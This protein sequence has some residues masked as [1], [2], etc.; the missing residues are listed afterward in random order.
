[1]KLFIKKSFLFGFCVVAILT[2]L[3]FIVPI[4]KNAYL[5]A[6]NKK[7]KLLEETPSPRIIFIGGSNV[8]FGLDCKRIKD[9]LHINVVNAGLHA[10]IGLKYMLDDIALYVRKGDI[11]I[12][13]PE[14]THFYGDMAGQ[15]ETIAGIM[16]ITKFKNV[17]MLNTSQWINVLK[18][19]PSDL[20]IRIIPPK[21]TPRAYKA[22][23]FNEYGDEVNHWTLSSIP[24]A[25]PT[26]FKDGLNVAMCN[27]FIDRL[28]EL[29]M[30]CNVIVVPPAYRQAAFDINKKNVQE[31]TEFLN[32]EGFPFAISPQES[33]FL[34]EYIYDSDNHLNKKGVDRRTTLLI[35]YLK[36]VLLN[37]KK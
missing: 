18:G 6:Y 2:L 11:V 1:M 31:V 27:Y 30:R 28:K 16:S 37:K 7:Y 13:A 29:Q 19:I 17:G 26:K 4:N 23:N 12:W 10:G 8:A 15:P 5:Y 3:F 36:N 20:G 21:N 24:I 34:D 14:Y 35:K 9:S 25:T 33:V 32:R 22:S